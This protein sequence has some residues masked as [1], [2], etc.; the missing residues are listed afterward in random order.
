MG[1]LVARREPSPSPPLAWS[2]TWLLS[3]LQ[4]LAGCPNHATTDWRIQSC[5]AP[6]LQ[7]RD[8]SAPAISDRSRTY[9]PQRTG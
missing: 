5:P 9:N 2:G 7:G 4:S 1:Q 3:R 6:G 8:Q